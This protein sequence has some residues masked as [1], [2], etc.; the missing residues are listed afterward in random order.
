MLQ[1]R[2]TLCMRSVIH[3]RC[4]VTM[5]VAQVPAAAVTAEVLDEGVSLSRWQQARALVPDAGHLRTYALL[6]QHVRH[7]CNIVCCCSSNAQIPVVELFLRYRGDGE[8]A[9]RSVYDIAMAG[10]ADADA[11]AE[12][13]SCLLSVRSSCSV[14][15]MYHL[16]ASGLI[17]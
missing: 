7:S 2:E 3:C 6:A 1:A 16:V 13:L 17:Q 14:E 15:P 8:F 11:G 10:G 4:V 12:T 9:R 5:V